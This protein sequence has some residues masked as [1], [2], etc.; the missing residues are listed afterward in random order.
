M[1]VYTLDLRLLATAFSGLLFDKGFSIAC[2]EGDWIHKQG[3]P[4]FAM[5]IGNN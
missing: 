5:V 3:A 4:L 1:Q 2:I